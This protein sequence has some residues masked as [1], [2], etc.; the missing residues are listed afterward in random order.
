MTET[1]DSDG[2]IVPVVSTGELPPPQ[3]VAGL[4]AEAYQRYRTLDDG[5]VADYIPILGRAS[6]DL[7]G[8]S[9]VGIS[10]AVHE[11][12]D[13]EHP[14]SI[15]S[16]SKPFVFA[17]VAQ[18]I[19]A[20]EARRKVGVN[21]TGLPFNS[22]MAV[23]LNPDRTMNPM[24]NAGA[25]ATTSLCPGDTAEAKW[26]FIQEGLSRF[27]GRPLVLDEE[28]YQSEAETNLRNRGIAKLLEGYGRMYF[29]ALEATDVY[30]RQ[31][32]LNVTAHDLAVMGAT[33]AD[34]GVNPVTKERVIDAPLCRHVL[35]ALATAGLY[36][37]SGDWLYEIGLP[38][39]S[40][41]S[42]GIV[43]IAP[44]KGSVGTFSPPLDPA[45]NSVRGQRATRFLSER[46][47]LN[48][49]ASKPYA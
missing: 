20:E 38:G 15:Q 39:K 5:V 16:I 14:F 34:G 46:L 7:F 32:S 41:V 24:V 19:G 48:L 27:A 36:E 29:D 11:A 44:G 21:A 37:R 33:L 12:G 1:L 22:V 3:Q 8:V 45:G 17:L 35:A 25:I 18:V 30:T 26:R 6:R 42:G 31:C 4:V 28:V 9:A 10:G 23:E 49:F 43:T 47:G 13:C 40:G 2:Q